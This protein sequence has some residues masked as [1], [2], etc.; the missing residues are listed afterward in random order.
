MDLVIFIFALALVPLFFV[1]VIALFVRFIALVTGRRR[2]KQDYPPVRVGEPVRTTS[3]IP[4]RV[5][6]PGSYTRGRFDPQSYQVHQY[7]NLGWAKC[8]VC[9][10][11]VKTSIADGSLERHDR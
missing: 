2:V 7:Q 1:G 10:S 3:Q 9:L 4:A 8:P 11:Y 5:Q 6:C